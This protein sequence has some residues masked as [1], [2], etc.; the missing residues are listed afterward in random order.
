MHNKNDKKKKSQIVSQ[1]LAR[2]ICISIDL[3]IA[4]FL[5]TVN[6]DSVTR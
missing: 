4:L 3:D 5:R 2:P 1:P 6:F